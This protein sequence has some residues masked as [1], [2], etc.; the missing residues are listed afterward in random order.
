M[1]QPRNDRRRF[2][3]INVRMDVVLKG[4]DASGR[5]FFERTEV[6]SFDQR[7]ARAHTRFSLTPGTEVEIQLSTETEGKRLRVVWQGEPQ[8]LHS[9]LVGLEMVDPNDSWSP[10]T[11]KAQWE[12]REF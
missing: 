4:I 3:R 5:E 6:D 12:A 8:S 9:G 2:K 11:L 1:A 10:A 7:G